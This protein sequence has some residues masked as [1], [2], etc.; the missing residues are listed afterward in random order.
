MLFRTLKSPGERRQSSW[1]AIFL[2]R[3]LYRLMIEHFLLCAGWRAYVYLWV[4]NVIKNVDLGK[5]NPKPLPILILEENE[6]I[7]ARTSLG[8]GWGWVPGCDCE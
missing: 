1:E 6:N 4:R 3:N 2:V 8:W 5:K 7:E